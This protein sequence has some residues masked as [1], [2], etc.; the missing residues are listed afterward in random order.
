MKKIILFGLM[1]LNFSACNGQNDDPYDPNR[2][3]QGEME[4]KI[5]NIVLQDFRAEQNSEYINLAFDLYLERPDLNLKQ[6]DLDL[7]S[8][9]LLTVDL[10]VSLQPRLMY[11]SDVN[12]KM[13][14]SGN[15]CDRP[16]FPHRCELSL[17]QE[18]IE[19]GEG[20][21]LIKVLFED[22]IYA[23]KEISIKIPKPLERPTLISPTVTPEQGSPV[24]MSFKSSPGAEKY[25]VDIN[26]CNDYQ[27]DGINPCLDGTSYNLSRSYM[28]FEV[29]ETDYQKENEKPFAEMRDGIIYLNSELKQVF[30][31]A[32]EYRIVA[33]TKGT[34]DEGISTFLETTEME[35]FVKE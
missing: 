9:G 13:R 35:V 30:E 24:K 8:S 21:Y 33:S 3:P 32:V 28:N 6:A 25:T 19:K 20:K 22:E 12:D 14:D 4:V 16:R 29:D 2:F 5:S 34:N 27:N 1:I 11:V 18:D 31:D 10:P 17:T 15:M 26:L 7:P 23:E